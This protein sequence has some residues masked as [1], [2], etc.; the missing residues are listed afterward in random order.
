MHIPSSAIDNR[1]ALWNL[2]SRSVNGKPG[3]G[4]NCRER[5]QLHT[6]HSIYPGRAIR[7]TVNAQLILDKALILSTIGIVY[8]MKTRTI[9]DQAAITVE[10]GVHPARQPKRKTATEIQSLFIDSAIDDCR[11]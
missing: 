9:A 8:W 7:Q 3:A 6:I 5:L 1:S 10:N 4:L 2:N 11:P